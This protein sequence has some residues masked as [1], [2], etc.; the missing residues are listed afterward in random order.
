MPVIRS[1]QLDLADPS[2]D[3]ES[4]GQRGRSLRGQLSGIKRWKGEED[5]RDSGKPRKGREKDWQDGLH[6]EIKYNKPHS[7]YK[8]Y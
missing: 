5:S 7:W 4:R 1:T 8:L 3:G 6:P 2:H